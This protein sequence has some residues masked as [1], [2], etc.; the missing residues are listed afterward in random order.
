MKVESL[1]VQYRGKSKRGKE[2]RGRKAKGGD[3]IVLADV[4]NY[5]LTKRDARAQARGL[6]EYRGPARGKRP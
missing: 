5:Q 6:E 1:G 4:V 2:S 3:S